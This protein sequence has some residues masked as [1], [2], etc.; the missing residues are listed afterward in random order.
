[1]KRTWFLISILALSPFALNA[2]ATGNIVYGN[3]RAQSTG[4]ATGDLFAVEPKGSVPVSFIEANVLLSLKADQYQAVFALAQEG[5]TLLEGNEKIAAQTRDFTTSLEALGVKHTDIFVDFISQNRVHDFTV[6]DNVARE[7]FSGFEVKKNVIVR[8]QDPALLEQM[9]A[10]AAKSAVFDLVKVDYVVSDLAA[11]RARLMEEASKIVKQKE[12][13]YKRLFGV[14][15]RP[16]SVH[17]EKYNA[18]FPSDMY[19][20]Y[21]AYESG[22][23]DSYNLRVVRNRKTSTFYYSPLDP[24]GFDAVI[25]P[26]GMEPVVQLTL[27]LKIKYR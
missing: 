16:A 15:M 13:S 25:N 6:A 17:Q 8:Y 12:A 20:S 3:P 14:T 27:Y 19:K 22:S 2:Q 1:M 4:V 21:T 24:A 11:A 9:L 10:A 5:P 26:A 23:A 18:F 7:K